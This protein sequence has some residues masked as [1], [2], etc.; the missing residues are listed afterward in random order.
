LKSQQREFVSLDRYNSEQAG[1]EQEQEGVV[2]ALEEKQ[3]IALEEK[4]V[5]A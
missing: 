4:Q 5:I 3:V 1:V 2:I